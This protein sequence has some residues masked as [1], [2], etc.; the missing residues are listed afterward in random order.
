[1]P[2]HMYALFPALLL[3]FKCV[4]EDVFCEG[5]HHHMWFYLSLQLCQN[6]GLSVLPLIGE[7]A[8]LQGGK[9]GT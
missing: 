1:V 8:K 3:F 9:Q 4:L 7:I 6:S 2:F 5:V